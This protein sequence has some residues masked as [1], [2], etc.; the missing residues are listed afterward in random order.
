M[1]SC[2]R[3]QNNFMKHILLSMEN[4]PQI[5]LAK[6]CQFFFYQFKYSTNN[7]HIFYLLIKVENI[8]SFQN[9]FVGINLKG[10][11]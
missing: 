5:F 10:N 9:M 1:V 6:P 8:I 2:S 4:I 7:Q 11:Y 3:F